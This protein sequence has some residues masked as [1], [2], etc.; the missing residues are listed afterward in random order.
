MP[1]KEKETDENGNKLIDSTAIDTSNIEK[2]T[3]V[4]HSSQLLDTT[5]QDSNMF[6]STIDK[7]ILDK[8]NEDSLDVSTSKEES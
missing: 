1:T 5:F 4:D 8:I 7:I 3:Y 6:D 2:P